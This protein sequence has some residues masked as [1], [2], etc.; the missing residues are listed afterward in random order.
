MTK[1]RVPEITPEEE[2]LLERIVAEG[3]PDDYFPT[4]EELANARPFSE[5]ETELAASIVR[6]RPDLAEPM[7]Q[8]AE[9]FHRRR[10]R[11]KLANARQQVSIRL[12]P[13]VLAKLKATG[14]GWQRRVNDILRKAVG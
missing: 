8:H 1:R 7:R 13:D 9:A 11:P 2:A 12:D 4:D 10:G 14:P 5:A 3:D 6:E